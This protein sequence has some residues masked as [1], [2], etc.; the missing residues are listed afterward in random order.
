M[1]ANHAR[2]LWAAALWEAA[3]EGEW[4]EMELPENSGNPDVPS[5]SC[6]HNEPEDKLAVELGGL[7][8]A[9]SG[10]SGHF[11]RVLDGYL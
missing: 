8:L 4:R 5:A 3:Q 7:L 10:A 6:V 9:V 11:L 1:K 2:G